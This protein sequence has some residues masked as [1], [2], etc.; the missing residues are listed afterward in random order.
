[1]KPSALVIL[2]LAFAFTVSSRGLLAQKQDRKQVFVVPYSH[3]DLFWGGT[4]EETLSRG[5]RII[6]RAMQLAE[7]HPEFRFLLEDDDFV[8]NFMDSHAGTR[9]AA[10]LQSLVRSGRIEIAP[11]WSAIYQNLPRGEALVRNVTY[12]KRYARETFGVDPLVAVL[13][14]IPGFTRQYPQILRDADVPYMVMTRM[15]PTDV[16]LFD[17]KA[18]DGSKVLVW[19]AVK[20]YGWGL[21]LGMIKEMNDANITEIDKDVSSMQSLTKGPVYMGWGADLYAP[22]ETLISNVAALNRH[23][24][25]FSFHFATPS[26]YFR[27]AEKTPSLPVLSGEITG[28]WANVNSSA[29]AIWPP[30]MGATDALLN[31]EKFAAINY[32][33]GYAPYPQQQF[34]RLWKKVLESLDHNFYGQGGDL[35][36]AEK[37]GFANAA[38]LES[39][40]ILR[41]SLRDIAERVRHPAEK[42]TLIV[43]FNPMGWRRD[44]VVRAHVPVY[45]DVAPRE[46]ADY[47]AAMRLTDEEGHSIPFDVE[48]YSENMSRALNLVFTAQ[49]V[50]SVGYKSYYLEPVDGGKQEPA[51]QVVMDEEKNKSPFR[52]Q[53]S[54]TVENRFYRVTVDRRTGRLEIFDKQLNRIMCKDAEIVGMET[55]GGDAISVFPYTGRTIPNVVDSVELSQNGSAETVLQI[56]GS[57]AG[58]PVTQQ[59]TLYRDIPQ[60][61]IENTVDWK[62][63][64]Y[65]ELQQVFPIDMTGV[66]VRNGVPFGSI[67]ATDMME[68]AGIR[69]A[70]EVSPDVWKKWRQIQN[71]ITA[72]TADWSFTIAA[73]RQLFTVDEHA[74]RGDMLRGT[75]YN[76][77]RS[78]QHGEAVAIQ[79]PAQGRYVYRYSV[80]SEK[81]NWAASRAWQ[82]GMNFN[83]PLIPVVSEDELSTKSLPPDQAFAS[84][85]GDSLVLSAV[86]K[87]DK[88]DEIVFRLFDELGKDAKTHINFL[89]QE[90]G[91][92]TVNLLEEPAT[93]GGET[94]GQQHT[95]LEVSPFQIRTVE[96]ANPRK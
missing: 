32:A 36:D 71:W 72:S 80:S 6:S 64:R 55:R 30:A 1:M 37:V 48:S 43:V 88:G 46:I 27:A 67:S 15:G 49:G 81:G 28:S 19:D 73:D 58:E 50:P 87:A 63:G 17:W 21:K 45:G 26:E 51:S 61:D 34:D 39:G 65:M 7:Q 42:A 82:K 66:E 4:E 75:S 10:R 76:Q 2:A 16:P 59:V 74:I 83:N 52:V 44:D 57:V 60:I 40:Q 91:F 86:K 78:Y 20:G 79:Q 12:G 84:V 95:V 31:A 33:L 41:A 11:L 35:G 68:H 69:K 8:A 62:P 18:P 92:R 77:L 93:D 9:D 14:D 70:D 24:G 29:S 53:G 13:T 25:P 90:R 38:T 56:R 23:E 47:R 96:L 94:A 5:S 54:D 22:S 89:G 3:L 85:D